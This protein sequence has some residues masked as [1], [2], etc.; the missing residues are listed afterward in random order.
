MKKSISVRLDEEEV[1]TLEAL[2]AEQFE[3]F[4]ISMSQ[5]ALLKQ[6]I[7][8]GYKQIREFTKLGYDGILGQ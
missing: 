3:A 1:K 6:A 7:Q 4:G 2:R 5:H 8:M